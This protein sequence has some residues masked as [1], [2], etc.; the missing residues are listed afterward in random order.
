ML[1]S[2]VDT[3]KLDP[4]FVDIRTSAPVYVTMS[5]IPSRMPNTFKIVDHFLKH[6]KGVAKVIVNIPHRY[7]RWPLL[8]PRPETYN[9]ITDPRLIVQR[10]EDYGPLTKLLPSLPILPRDAIVIVAD[11]MCYRLDAFRDIAELADRRRSEAFSFYVY[12]YGPGNGPPNGV[13]VDVPQ[14]ADLIATHT[15]NLEAFP[16]WFAA[17]KDKKKTY[18]DSPCFFVDDQVIGWYFKTTQ[19]PMVQVDRHHRNIY[20][21]GCD[22][23]PK[24]DN[25]NRQT[26]TRSRDHTMKGCFAEMQKYAKENR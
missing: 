26:G 12:P 8:V 6:V 3:S 15:S 22:I 14:G 25:L 21:K 7:K 16:R 11:D 5:T 23:A 10:T 20:I 18:F 9:T 13:S 1:V 24:H 2:R 19:V 17:F 4:S